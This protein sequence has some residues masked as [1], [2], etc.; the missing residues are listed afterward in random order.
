MTEDRLRQEICDVGASIH[1]RG[2]T[3][4]ATGN[5]SAR[6]DDGW[7]MTP[8]GSNLGNLDPDRMSRLDGN[9]AHIGGDKPTKE[10]FLHLA[11]YGQ[12]P[13]SGA[14]VHL[15][16]TH[17]VAV[18]VLADLDP[19]DL[20][21]PITAYYVM[22][23]GKLPLVPFYAPGDAKLAQAVGETAEAH[24]AMLLAN[25]GPVV[26]GTSLSAALDAA[27]E[28]EETARLF[29][30]LQGHRTRYLTKQQVAALR[31]AFPNKA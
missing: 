1:S 13:G 20:L 18:S 4:G 12:R 30:L 24:H 10:N 14:I 23:V 3:H 6:L 8:T 22:R 21:P 27:E 2:L 26:A 17:S 9:G 29:L 19:K 11:V 15:H 31:D 25:H 16:S 28:L 7:L 5:I